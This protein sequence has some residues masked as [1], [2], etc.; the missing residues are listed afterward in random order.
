[1]GWYLLFMIPVAGSWRTPVFVAMLPI[2][3]V[4]FAVITLGFVCIA[5][6]MGWLQWRYLEGAPAVRRTV[7]PIWR[8]HLVAFWG[9]AALFWGGFGLGLLARDWAYCQL[10]MFLLGILPLVA[11]LL[12]L[13]TVNIAIRRA[14]AG[15]GS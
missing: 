11:A 15:V 14:P 5:Q 3:I 8:G 1:M 9:F 4:G 2:L 6:I 10:P 13:V 12:F 7:A